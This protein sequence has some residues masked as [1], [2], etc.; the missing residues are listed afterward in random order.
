M[1]GSS[2]ARYSLRSGSFTFRK[3]VILA[4]LI[5]LFVVPGLLTIPKVNAVTT[6]NCTYVNGVPTANCNPSS[7]GGNAV[8]G[9]TQRKVF[10][11]NG[12]TP[13]WW[14]FWATGG[15]IDYQSCQ[16]FNVTYCDIQAN[17]SNAALFTNVGDAASAS[18]QGFTG[19]L[20]QNGANYYLVYAVAPL[21][22]GT[23]FFW[24]MAQLTNAG[25]VSWVGMPQDQGFNLLAGLT[26]ALLVTYGILA[27]DGLSP[28]SPAPVRVM[29]MT[30][31][32]WAG[33]TRGSQRRC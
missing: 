32:R 3:A 9:G 28:A 1:L 8:F 5:V 19:W 29:A 16:A 27:L 14:I 13:Y 4:A 2:P 11:T 15:Q 17:W 7:G 12:A 10:E 24:G 30:P 25:T 31:A 26:A 23:K 33:S 20:L 22:A 21:G 18:G 6:T